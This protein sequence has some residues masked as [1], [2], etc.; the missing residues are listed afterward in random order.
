MD[1]MVPAVQGRVKVMGAILIWTEHGQ[2]QPLLVDHHNSF[3][4][5][6]KRCE[7]DNKLAGKDIELC[8]NRVFCLRFLPLNL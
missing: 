5:H 2:V 3:F 4:S 7:K 8:N 6:R 1:V